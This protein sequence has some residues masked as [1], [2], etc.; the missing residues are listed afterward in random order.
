ML[1]DTNPIYMSS[2]SIYVSTHHGG[3][4]DDDDDAADDSGDD[5]DDEGHAHDKDGD[6]GHGPWSMVHG[7]DD[8]DDGD[9]DGDEAVVADDG[10][11]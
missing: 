3:V 4:D 6:D 7:H 2:A 9:D 11:D 10:Q 1:K 8:G 5:E